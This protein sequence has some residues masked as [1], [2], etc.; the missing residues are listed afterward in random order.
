[1]AAPPLLQLRDEMEMTALVEPVVVP[2]ERVR[3]PESIG[4]H[5][6]DAAGRRAPE[7]MPAKFHHKSPENPAT[8]QTPG[9]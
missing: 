1:M 5:G 3:S 8:V 2:G 6:H 7:T 9:R 4:H